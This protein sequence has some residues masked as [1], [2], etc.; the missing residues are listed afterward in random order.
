MKSERDPQLREVFGALGAET[1]RHAPGFPA[2]WSS[3]VDRASKHA[4]PNHLRRLVWTGT[5]AAVLLLALS[6]QLRRP[7]LPSDQEAL[8]MAQSLAAWTAPSDELL[9]MNTGVSSLSTLPTLS[10]QSFDLPAVVQPS[11][12]G[13]TDALEITQ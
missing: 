2:L 9:V 3:A 1:R 5:A 7:S 11:A 12:A 6:L 8:A 4:A 13:S 10:I